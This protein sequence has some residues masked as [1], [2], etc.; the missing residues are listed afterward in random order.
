[1]GKLKHV[2]SIDLQGAIAQGC[3][4]MQRVFN[5]DDDNI[6][7]FKSVLAPEARLSFNASHSESHVPGRH[8]NALLAAEAV[9]GVE[10]DEQAVHHHARA[11]FFSFSGPLP[12]PLNRQVI[13][14]PLVNFLPHNTREGMHALY[15]L[16]RYRD[17]GQAR[18]IAERM[19]A[20]VMRMWHPRRRWDRRDFER[21]GLVLGEKDNF[22]FGEARLIGPLVKYYRATGNGSALELALA[23]KQKAVDEFF[24]DDGGYDPEIFGSH[25]HST[26]SVMSSLAQLADLMGDATLMNRVRA[27]YDNGLQQVRDPLGWSIESSICPDENTDLGESNNTGDIVETALILGRWGYPGCFHDAERIVRAHLLPSQ[28][29]DTSFIVEPPN[30]EGADGKRRL[31]ERHLGAFGTPAPYGH[32]PVGFDRVIFNMDIVGGAVGSLCEVVRESTRFDQAG[33]RVNLLF[34]RRTPEIEVASPYT[35][36][37]LRITV[38]RPG[39]LFVRIPPWVDREALSLAGHD[40]RW[41]FAGEHLFIPKP[42]VDAPITVFF[43][44]PMQEIVLKHRLRDIRVRLRGDEVV[45]MDNFGADLTFFDPY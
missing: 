33:H 23:L 29:Q 2:N 4:T 14:G 22:I 13:G 41:R 30:P 39:P 6:P 7:F 35:Q 5:A 3:Q 40:G 32:R 26:T 42:R 21:W 16:A 20:T 38:K 19:I 1:M 18:G 8:L 17:S 27:F 37:G 10:I 9:A 24:R 36:D 45:A 34:D 44:R 43:D 28:L 15:A 11:A 12:L 25:V 31:A